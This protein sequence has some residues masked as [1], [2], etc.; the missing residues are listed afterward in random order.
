MTVSILSK[1]LL[2]ASLISS[3]TA[4]RAGNSAGAWNSI[5]DLQPLLSSAAEIFYPGSVGYTNATTRWSAD[6]KPGLDV[7]VKV[8]TEED[9][10]ATVGSRSPFMLSHLSFRASNFRS[11]NFNY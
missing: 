7:I 5:S 4:S 9:V 8:A 3:I 10:Q 11:Q 1:V 6:T 2:L